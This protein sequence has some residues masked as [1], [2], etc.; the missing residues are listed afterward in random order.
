MVVMCCNAVQVIINRD[1]WIKE[2]VDCEAVGALVTC[3]AIIRC[4]IQQGVDAEDL[5]ITLMGDA[6]DCLKNEPPAVETARAIFNF[7]IERFPNKEHL[8]LQAVFLEKD[9][10][11]AAST[12]ARLKEAVKNCPRDEILW[13]IA[14]KQKWLADDLA[15]AR[16]ILR[17]AFGAIPTSQQI[18]LAAIKLEWENNEF[19]RARAL[20][21]KAREHA[22]CESVWLKSALLERELGQPQV[23]VGLLLEAIKIDKYAHFAKFYMMAGQIYTEEL[24]ELAKAFSIYQAG[25]KVAPQSVPLWQLLI[26][27]AEKKGV[28]KARPICSEARLK[29]P[30]ND[31]IWLEYIRLERRSGDKKQAESLMAQALQECPS[32]GALWAEELLTCAKERQKSRSIDALKACVDD[33]LV[34]IAVGRLFERGGRVLKARRRFDRALALNPRLGDGW[35]YYFAMEYVHAHKAQ[36]ITTGMLGR[37]GAGAVGAAA[38]AEGRGLSDKDKLLQ[39]G[40]LDSVDDAEEDEPASAST[41]TAAVESTASGNGSAS[42][43]SAAAAVAEDSILDV[44]ERKVQELTPNQGELWCSVTKEAKNRRLPPAA[45]LRVVAE[46]IL[47]YPLSLHTSKVVVNGKVVASK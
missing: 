39:F 38:G 26:R 7:A 24:N 30:K 45:A 5:L 31:L 8:W 37:G 16:D 12:E 35:A 20:L 9:H 10:G 40:G 23:A 17:E 18:W 44:I 6:A 36:L 46:R 41:A 1:S 11:T 15:G 29:L 2:A 4:T 42:T 14:A 28:T 34:L 27:L 33:P 32:S 3:A 25:L 21:S 13:L 19:E 43:S 22:S 47:G